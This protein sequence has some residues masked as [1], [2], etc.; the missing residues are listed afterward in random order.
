MRYPWPIILALVA[1]TA[2]VVVI[3]VQLIQPYAFYA[4]RSNSTVSVLTGTGFDFETT[5][6]SVQIT[7]SMTVDVIYANFS[8]VVAL[9]SPTSAD[10]SFTA[11]SWTYALVSD[12]RGKYI[13][14]TD[15]YGTCYAVG[16][17]PDTVT[18]AGTTWYLFVPN[19]TSTTPTGTSLT[20]CTI[21][22]KFTFDT[23]NKVWGAYDQN[24]NPITINNFRATSVTSASFSTQWVYGQGGY[25]AQPFWLIYVYPYASGTVQFKLS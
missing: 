7:A 23:T 1:T 15:P 13:K 4:S 25:V 14:V 9:L 12:P 11:N 5:A 20:G 8:W 2:I 10:F 3:T 22:T 24:N 17:T 16:A 21:L 6:K 18:I 19:M